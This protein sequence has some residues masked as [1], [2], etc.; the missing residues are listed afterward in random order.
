MAGHDTGAQPTG[1]VSRRPAARPLP[2]KLN[3]TLNLAKR[4]CRI[5]LGTCHDA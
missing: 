2:Q 1:D 3:A 4:A 5:V